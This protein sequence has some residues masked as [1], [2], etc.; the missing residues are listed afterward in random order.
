MAKAADISELRIATPCTV[1]WE[2][3]R[4]DELVRYCGQ[5]KL[6]V[7]NISELTPEQATEL[8]N[9]KAGRIC[10][11]LYER[12]DGTIILQD[13]PYGVREARNKL[14]KLGIAGILPPIMVIAVT[15][16]VNGA[17]NLQGIFNQQQYEY[18]SVKNY[19]DG[20]PNL[21]DYVVV[22]KEAIA[23]G[24]YLFNKVELKEVL[25]SQVPQHAVQSPAGL[26]SATAT[27]ALG[28]GQIVFEHDVT[29]P[30]N[31]QQ[32]VVTARR[33]IKKGKQFS[34]ENTLLKEVT[35]DASSEAALHSGREVIGTVADCDIEPG[36]WISRAMTK[37]V[38]SK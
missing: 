4:G 32:V 10:I 24:D 36:M 16:Y 9:S 29:E 34:L 23:P 19:A 20:G 27:R 12:F 3:M 21:K 14:L 37:P 8:I 15:Y 30:G 22:A 33:R 2:N 5:C 38:K 11:R 17:Y 1:G 13:C 35:R 26:K 18:N 7:Y 31:S 28:I 6:D 25:K